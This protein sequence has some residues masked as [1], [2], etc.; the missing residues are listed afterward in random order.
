[1]E[2]IQ[3]HWCEIE[4]KRNRGCELTAHLNRMYSA[5][6]L[7]H[8]VKV[9]FEIGNGYWQRMRPLTAVELV[10]CDVRFN[11][12]MVMSSKEA[13][14]SAVIGFCLGDPIWWNVEGNR[15]E[16]GLD[17]GEVSAFFNTESSNCC[18]YDVHRHFQGLTLKLNRQMASQ[19]LQHL[20]I[21]K[22]MHTFFE[23]KG[24]LFSSKMTP[25]MKQITHEILHCRYT[26]DVKQIYL[27]AKVLEL[28]ALYFSESLLQ[29]PLTMPDLSRT[30]LAALHRAKEILDANL[31]TPPGLGELAKQVCLNE[32]KLK[33]G[34][35]ELFGFPVH[36]Y[37]IDCRLTA[38]YYMLEEGVV[39]ITEAA[40]AVGFSKAGHF[41]DQFK[42]KYGMKPSEYFPH[43][44]KL[45]GERLLPS[46]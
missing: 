19:S 2:N 23:K 15:K 21:D 25:G 17:S 24:Q 39:N 30:D 45:S 7:E 5:D 33:K 20:P 46:Q 11:K 28:I 38:A 37:V 10:L 29:K 35:K 42:R 8:Q 4:N 31:L 14:D 16:F 12:H 18:E 32:Y 40:Y 44:R 1:M 34:F 3:R 22:V 9:P 26:G 27:S 43:H 13:E 6:A 36:A 41:S